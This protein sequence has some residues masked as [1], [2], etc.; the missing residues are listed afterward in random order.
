MKEN[1]LTRLVDYAD[2]RARCATPRHR[3]GVPV[4]KHLTRAVLFALLTTTGHLAMAALYGHGVDLALIGAGL[5]ILGAIAWV[6]FDL[7]LENL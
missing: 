2:A 6:G 7:A 3:G 4:G 1:N 5:Q